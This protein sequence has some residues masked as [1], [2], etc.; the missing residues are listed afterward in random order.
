MVD[1]W[2]VLLSDQR[3]E[4]ATDGWLAAV[5]GTSVGQRDAVRAFGRLISQGRRSIIVRNGRTRLLTG[6]EGR[7][8]S[9]RAAARATLVPRVKPAS[10]QLGYPV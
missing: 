9:G 8:T 4:Q 6:V 1:H 10:N 2:P 7:I 3:T 5:I